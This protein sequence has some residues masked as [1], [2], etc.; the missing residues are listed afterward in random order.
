NMGT[1]VVVAVV[2]G[3]KLVVAHLGDSR[4][5]RYRNGALEAITVDHN[6]AQA[7]YEQQT[8]TKEELKNHRFRHV[9]WKFLG[10]KEAVEGPDLKVVE[11]APGDRV[12]MATDGMTGVV[13]DD[14]VRKEVEAQPDAQRLADRLVQLSLETGSKDNVTCVVLNIVEG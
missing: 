1:T 4:A 6:L 14:V 2:R 7:L 11:V 9:L 3:R 8:I 13:E 5:Y 10:S 12:I